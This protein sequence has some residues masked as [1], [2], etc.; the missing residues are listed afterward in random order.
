MARLRIIQKRKRSHTVLVQIWKGYRPSRFGND[1]TKVLV[2]QIVVIH[3][4]DLGK[5]KNERMWERGNEEMRE[6]GRE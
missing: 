3:P 5:I 1:R 4:E 6:R 2:Q